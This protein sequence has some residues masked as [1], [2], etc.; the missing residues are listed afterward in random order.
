MSPAWLEKC[1]RKKC[2][3]KKATIYLC[4]ATLQNPL[5]SLKPPGQSIHPEMHFM[6]DKVF[7]DTNILVYSR[8]AS[9]PEKQNQTMDWMKYLW[10]SKTGRLSFQVLNEFYSTVTTKLKPGMNLQDARDDIIS[11]F[12]W[13]PIQVST[14]VLNGAWFIQDQFKL[15][16]WDALIVSAA[17]ICD[18]N[19]LLT[20]D[21]QE[22]QLI[23]NVRII[24]PFLHSPDFLIS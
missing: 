16:W 22:N 12:A 20:E 1:L 17:Q 11:L 23:G 5:L 19:Y 7:V 15:S 6:N 13:H 10:G 2:R 24:S 4:N 21:L 18:C 3:K 8:D 9:E 14:E